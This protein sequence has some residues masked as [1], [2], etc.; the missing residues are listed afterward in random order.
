MTI[1]ANRQDTIVPIDIAINDS[2]GGVAGLTVAM[3]VRD[4]TTTDMYLDFN[5][6]TFKNAG[7]GNRTTALTDLTTGVYVLNG[8]L[9]VSTWANLNANRLAVSLEFEVTGAVNAI[10]TDALELRNSD[11]SIDMW[12]ILGLD[13][14]NPLVDNTTYRRVPAGG[15]LIDIGIATVGSQVTSTRT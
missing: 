12:R 4:A 1:T 3:A 2:S 14:S 8:G 5:D 6:V 13:A 10:V 11:Q 15:A 7:W 9:N